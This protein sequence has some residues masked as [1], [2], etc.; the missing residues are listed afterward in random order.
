MMEEKLGKKISRRSFLKGAAAGVALLGPGIPFITRRATAAEPLQIGVVSPASGNYADHGMTERLGMQMAVD[1]FKEKG[2]LGRPVKLIVEDDETDPQVGARKARRLIEVEKVKY[3]IGGVSSSVAVSVGE[4]AQRNGALFIATNQNSDTITGEKAHRCVF[5]V[6][7]DMSMALRSLSPYIIEKVGKKW[8]FFTHDYEW[9]WSG[10]RW[11][12]K[13]L[14]QYKGTEVGESKIPM[15]TRDFSSFLIKA[16]SAKPE[17]LVITVGGIDRAAL[18]EQ[19]YEFGIQKE[20]TPVQTLYDYEDVWA[21]GAEKNFG[22]HGTE[23]Y[24]AIDAPGAK[25]FVAQYKKRW[26]AAL[27]PVPTQNTANGYIGMREL[28]RGI[29]RAGKDDVTAVIKAL[30]GHTVTDSIK[31]DPIYIREW[32]HQFIWAFY[33]V[34]AKKPSEMKDRTDFFE[35]VKWVPGKETARTKEE[36]PVKLEPYPA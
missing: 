18:I 14:E 17:A 11:A 12:R 23:W 31:N 8:Y 27:I 36:N 33:I 10:T 9:G 25:N 21:A 6:P 1:E 2:V 13:M 20:M 30:E 19:M 28:L 22:I 32:D 16:R 7:P 3:L 26:P 15:N 4:V 35:I 29:E 34:R 24:Y 5:R